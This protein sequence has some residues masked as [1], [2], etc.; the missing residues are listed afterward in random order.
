[1]KTIDKII[2]TLKNLGIIKEVA[3]ECKELKSGT[4]GN[5]I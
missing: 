1:M 5:Y 4:T 2:N 3:I